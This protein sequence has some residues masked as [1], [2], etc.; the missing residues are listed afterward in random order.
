ME[1][2]VYLCKVW[3]L[4]RTK[5]ARRDRTRKAR[6]ERAIQRDTR[7]RKKKKKLSD[8]IP[9]RINGNTKA[10]VQRDVKEVHMSPVEGSS[11][12]D[13]RLENHC[14]EIDRRSGGRGGSSQR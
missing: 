9:L 11:A 5:T 10:A 13:R 7:W 6:H 8:A 3:N 14:G 1:L 2:K 12:V 4:K